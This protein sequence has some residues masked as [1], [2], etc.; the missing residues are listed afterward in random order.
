MSE[1]I[2]YERVGDIAVLKAQNPPVNAL[3]VDVRK[4]LLAGIERAEQDGAKA[5]LIYGEGKTYF[6]GADIREFGKPPQEP[7]LPGLCSRIEATPLIVVSAMHGTALGGGLE[8][9]LASHYRIAVPS[10]KMGL[11]EV[12]LGI[13]PGAGGTQRLPRVA[14]TE[15]ALEMITTGRHISAAEAL[16]KGIIDRIEDGAPREIGLAYAQELLAQGAPRRAVGEMPAPEAVDFDAVYEA[17]LKKG[18]GQLSPAVAVRAVQAAAEAESFE[19][20]LKRERELFM[21]LMD[22]DQRQGLIHAFFSERAVSKLPELDGVAP[23]DV[24]SMGV[25]GGGTMGA[26]IAT[27]ALLAGLPVVLIEMTDEAVAAARGRIEGNLKGALKRGKISEEQY[28]QLTGDALTVATDYAALSA[29]DLVVEAVF[30]DMGVK[31]EVFG[32]LDA[33]CKPGAVL[34]T[35]T[36]YLDVDEIAAATSRPQDVIGLHFFSP[37]HVM[38]LLEVVVAEKT[39][40][41]VLATGFALGKRLKKVAV[42]S[43]ICDGFIGN[44]IMNAYR[45]A[46]EY[47][48]LDGASPYQVDKVV[49]GFGFPMGPF[50]MGD[51][52][53]LDINWAARKRRAPTRDP[54]ERVPR[55]YEMLCEGGDFGQKTGKGFYVYEEGRRGGVPNPEVAA[56]I[57]KDQ[58]QQGVTPR[59]F[60]DAEVLRRYMCAM[61][62]EAAKVVGEGIA[63]RPLDVDMVML[64][65]YGFLR[66]WGGPLKWADLQ[67]LDGILAD[68]RAYAAEDGFFWQPAPLLEQLVAEGRTFDSL[69]KGS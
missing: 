6:A 33:H 54:R 28:D 52:A 67:G 59:E 17:T 24:A 48:V 39:A 27:A 51:L 18:R 2:A 20:G 47:V 10:A 13:L 62:N 12:N 29:V 55:F 43:G 8:V 66:F 36:S 61:V 16:E 34:A 4:G 32:K 9:A 37:A 15:A 19:A 45:K 56:L 35:N 7:W 31:R 60:S 3:G 68:I 63:R 38:K 26:G 64:F 46:A 22:S 5:V 23:S 14:G 50:A 57:A 11:P 40:P 65:G 1:A 44:R 30:E 21:E 49:T 58:E 41:E 69:N 42:R 25:I 53:G